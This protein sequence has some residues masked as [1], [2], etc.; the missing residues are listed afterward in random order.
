[1]VRENPVQ[2]T[3]SHIARVLSTPTIVEN[4]FRCWQIPPRAVVVSLSTYLWSSFVTQP[5]QTATF[6]VVCKLTD[7]VVYIPCR[8]F[9]ADTSSTASSSAR[10]SASRIQCYRAPRPVRQTLFSPNNQS[11]VPSQCLRRLCVCDPLYVDFFLNK[12]ADVCTYLPYDAMICANTDVRSSLVW[13]Q[14]PYHFLVKPQT[15][16]SARNWV[17]TSTGL[18]VIVCTPSP[19]PLSLPWYMCSSQV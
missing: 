17:S 15:N 12:D 4:K 16:V 14:L 8:W 18:I 5:Q 13:I 3:H 7:C 11:A 9:A 19:S 1:M 2:R 6:I 10:V